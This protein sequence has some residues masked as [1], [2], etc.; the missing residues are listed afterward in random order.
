MARIGYNQTVLALPG[1]RFGR[2]KTYKKIF[3]G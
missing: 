2:R 1:Q 3:I